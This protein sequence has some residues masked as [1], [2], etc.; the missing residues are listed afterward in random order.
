MGGLAELF[1][2]AISMG[3][4]AWLAAVTDEKEFE[5]N[6]LLLTAA[7]YFTRTVAAGSTPLALWAGCTSTTESLPEKLLLL[8]QPEKPPANNKY[9]KMPIKID[10]LDELLG[11]QLK[12]RVS[13]QDSRVLRMDIEESSFGVMMA[14]LPASQGRCES[15]P[16]GS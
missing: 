1:A 13:G 8:V 2:G 3:L 4:G 5:V 9:E 6:D 15:V 12:E 16:I 11:E 7:E 14:R 10:R